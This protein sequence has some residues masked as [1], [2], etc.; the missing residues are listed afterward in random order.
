MRGPLDAFADYLRKDS[1]KWRE[2]IKMVNAMGEALPAV[3]A[4]CYKS[5]PF[6]S[7]SK[8]ISAKSVE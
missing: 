8:A 1:A 3:P 6:Q 7:S 4:V 2:V 5:M